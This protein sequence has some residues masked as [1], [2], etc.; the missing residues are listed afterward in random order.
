MR[1]ASSSSRTSSADP[2]ESDSSDESEPPTSGRSC[3]ACGADVSHR[4]KGAETCD[5][6]CRK[7]YERG[8]VA[9]AA[10]HNAKAVDELIQRLGL[11]ETVQRLAR[12]RLVAYGELAQCL[13]DIRKGRPVSTEEILDKIKALT[14]GLAQCFQTKRGARKLEAE[15]A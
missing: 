3:K 6:K 7:A 1:R 15:A 5:A 4:R 10:P 13:T 2:G 8:K 14:N 11:D 9:Q 12:A